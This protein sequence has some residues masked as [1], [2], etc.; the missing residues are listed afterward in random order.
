[1][2]RLRLIA[3][4]VTVAAL[5]GVLSTVAFAES[6]HIDVPELP[7]SAA[8]LPISPELAAQGVLW[9][10]DDLGAGE[11]V[12]LVLGGAFATRQ[13]AE[14]ANATILLGD[15][16]GYYVASTEQFQGLRDHLG[17]K[18]SDFVL[19]S[20]FRTEQGAADFIEVARANDAPAILTPRL[21][22]RGDEYVG[23]GQ[24]PHPDGS[25]PLIGPLAGVST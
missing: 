18:G 20:A 23:L 15:L 19:V 8:G 12:L 5:G 3:M 13:E 11:K 1:M 16:Q 10:G 25:G 21:L 4:G 17:S 22:N 9:H 6:H 2:K 24:E 7:P 14:R